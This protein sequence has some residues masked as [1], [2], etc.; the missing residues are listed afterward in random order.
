VLGD[1]VERAVQLDGVAVASNVGLGTGDVMEIRVMASSPVIGVPL[2]EL[3]PD[4]WRVAAIYRGD[5][6]VIPTGT[7]KIEPDDKVL[8]V[9]DP[10]FLPHVAENLR[11]GVP[12]FPLRHGPNVV[13]YLPRG[14]DRA[15][16]QE[17]EVLA[18]TTRAVGLA[19][20]YPGATPA[21]TVIAST[22][23]LD[24]SRAASGRTKWFDDAPLEGTLIEHHVAC[25]E[26][27]RPGVV[28]AGLGVRSFA[29]R[30]VGNAGPRAA[31]CNRIRVPVLFPRGAPRYER[32]LYLAYEGAT[33]RSAET[34]IDLARMYHLPLCILRVEL[35]RFFGATNAS[36]GTL[37]EA[38]ERRTRIYRLETETA[39]LLGNPIALT[40]ARASPSDMLIVD[41]QRSIRDSFTAPDIALRLARKAKCSV[42]VHTE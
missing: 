42:L 20:V 18:L 11:V 38:I 3:N 40:L 28:V 15:I 26:R 5:K 12:T 14:R 4:G 1:V 31:L 2:A 25:L 27:Y 7:S 24:P 22:P 34:A 33:I 16:E 36:V 37:I 13:V 19:R 41:R 32:V 39:S 9:G 30:L 35:P 29:D 17:A 21:R 10:E 8:L 6:L 23:G